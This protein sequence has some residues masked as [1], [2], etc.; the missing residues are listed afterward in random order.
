MP[1]DDDLLDLQVRD[2][3]LDDRG[4]VNVLG[5]HAVCDVAVHKELAGLAMADGGFWDAAVCTP[6][7]EDFRRLAFA[8]L[9]EGIRV[10]LGCLLGVDAVSGD[11]AVDSV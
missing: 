5:M 10:L 1:A 2:C 4:R 9:D 7:P 8:K 6:N 3:V 11:D